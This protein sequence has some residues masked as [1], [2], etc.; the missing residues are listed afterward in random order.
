[1]A[2]SLACDARTFVQNH[3]LPCGRIGAEFLRL[4]RE[5]FARASTRAMADETS[6]A[7]AHRFAI[8][9]R[10]LGGDGN[11]DFLTRARTPARIGPKTTRLEAAE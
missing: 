10:P 7:R 2:C 6:F 8:S 5:I 11:P 3:G 1:M 9:L 4:P